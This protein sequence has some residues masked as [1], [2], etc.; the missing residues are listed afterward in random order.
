MLEYTD[1]QSQAN[2]EKKDFCWEYFCYFKQ[3]AQNAFYKR[4]FFKYLIVTL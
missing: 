2:E 1:V 4:S 3:R